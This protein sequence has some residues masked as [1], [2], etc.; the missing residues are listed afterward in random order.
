MFSCFVSRSAL[1]S[2]AAAVLLPAGQAGA[3]VF[4]GVNEA[5]LDQPRIHAAIT[6][7]G[8]PDTPLVA[9]T[10]DIFGDPVET[11]T[12]QAFFD[13]GASGVLM[14]KE[15]ADALGVPMADG[16]AFGDVGVG[17]ISF[18]DVSD[19]VMV[20]LAP[21]TPNADVDNPD[22]FTSTYDQSFGPLRM[23]VAQTLAGLTGPLDVF[24]MPV[25]QGKTVV[26]DARPVNQIIGTINTTVHD[27]GDTSAF[28][29]PAHLTIPTTYADFAPFTTVTPSGAQ[30][31]TL[32]DN[33][34]I[35]PDPTAALGAAAPAGNTPGVQTFDDGQLVEG[36]WLFDTGAAT[37]IISSATAAGHHVRYVAGTEDTESPQLERFDPTD[38]DAP[39]T[40]L[41]E[42]FTLQIGGVGGVT[43]KA[44]FFLETLTLPT[45][46]G[47]PITF[48]HA[49]ALVADIELQ[50]PDTLE[51]LTLD[52][53]LGMNY[54]VGSAALD[55]SAINAGA[56]DFFT[57]DQPSGDIGLT[58]NPALLDTAAYLDAITSGWQQ[59]G[60][61]WD[62]GDLNGDGIVDEFDLARLAVM[63]PEGQSTTFAEAVAAAEFVPEPGTAAVLVG[64]GGVMAGYRPRRRGKR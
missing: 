48:T 17:G 4:S 2:A 46:E 11:F 52:G 19:D 39:G 9:E 28:V 49:P 38:P 30:G 6:L 7:P 53:I 45:V 20:R 54:F 18:F 56:F 26:M 23:Q 57:F 33:P 3:L 12:I 5:S 24:G 59:S 27:S 1:V 62:E 64:L 13:T 50:D 25:F 60:E 43:T 40:L 51:S 55:F 31:P 61:G 35:G 29:P 32:N 63:W 41:A 58:I 36:S 15:T 47:E 8:S 44:G 14:S 22:T 34:F 37:S 16:V 21:F 10:T 42:Q